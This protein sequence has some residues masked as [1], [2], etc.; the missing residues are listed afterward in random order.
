MP[1]ELSFPKTCYINLEGM[2]NDLSD[3]VVSKR[4]YSGLASFYL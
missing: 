1:L 2:L 3:D 4:V